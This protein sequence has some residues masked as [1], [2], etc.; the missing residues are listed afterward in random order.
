MYRLTQSFER[1]FYSRFQV[2]L[3]QT[4]NPRKE[5]NNAH[6]FMPEV[7]QAEKSLSCVKKLFFSA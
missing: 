3:S 6:S 7:S 2:E 1:G 5:T 4:D